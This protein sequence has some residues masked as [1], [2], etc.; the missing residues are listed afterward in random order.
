MPSL[1]HFNEIYVNT[2]NYN[3]IISFYELINTFDITRK[4]LIQY[5]KEKNSPNIVQILG[6]HPFVYKNLSKS[7]DRSSLRAVTILLI[8]VFPRI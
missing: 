2:T 3:D 8:F 1:K 6:I 7:C 5:L 4:E